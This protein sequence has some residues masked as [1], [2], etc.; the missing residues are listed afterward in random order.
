MTSLDHPH[1]VDAEAVAAARDR[2]IDA[3]EAGRLAGLLGL[4]ADPVRARLLYAL[5]LVDELCVGDLALALGASEDSV[6]YGLRVLRTA[7]LVST[8]RD[9]RVVYY[10]LSDGFPEPLRQHCLRALVELSRRTPGA[11]R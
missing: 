2:L 3:E 9:G 8:R 11:D 7:G 10:R 5:D 1:P 6:G 4:L